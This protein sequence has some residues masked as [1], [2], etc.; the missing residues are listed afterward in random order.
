MVSGSGFNYTTR[1]DLGYTSAPLTGDLESQSVAYDSSTYKITTG[2]AAKDGGTDLSADAEYAFDW[3]FL[4]HSDETGV[5]TGTWDMGPFERVA[6]APVLLG[7]VW[8]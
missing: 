2:T 1:A 5:R 4:Q 8:M 7:Q 3:D 6:A